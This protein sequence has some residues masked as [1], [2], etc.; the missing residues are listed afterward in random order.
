MAKIDI[1]GIDISLRNLGVS[2]GTIDLLTGEIS[3][4][5]LVLTETK[6][7]DKKTAKVVRKNSEDL[8][9]AIDLREA[10]HKQCEGAKLA[11]VEI[12]VGSQSARAMA[13]YGICIGVLASC[14]IPIVQVTPTEVK[15]AGAGHKTATKDEMIEW[16]VAKYPK[17][18]WLKVKRKGKVEI[19]AKNEHLADAIAA[20]HAGVLT[21]QFRQVASLMSA[22]KA[23]A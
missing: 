1:V 11:F 5:D 4:N 13:S 12:P 2:K 20:I 21:D 17:A 22:I 18:P 14:P 16:A 10:L 9:R 8:E 15:L 19:V 7:G 3:I 23:A 6:A